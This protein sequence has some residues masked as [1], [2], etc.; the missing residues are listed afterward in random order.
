MLLLLCGLVCCPWHRTASCSS[1][2]R[3]LLIAVC[4]GSWVLPGFFFFLRATLACT[5]AAAAPI[6]SLSMPCRAHQPSHMTT[7][8]PG[9][10]VS[11]Q[12]RRH[13]HAPIAP[14][15][16]VCRTEHLLLQQSPSWQ[17]RCQGQLLRPNRPQAINPYA[18]LSS[19]HAAW[20]DVCLMSACRAVGRGPHCAAQSGDPSR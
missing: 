8:T 3:P 1:L 18:A 20:G 15:T 9:N 5:T 12:H 16:S 17:A 2:L 10:K 7:S 11:V 4:I 13:R 6:Q 14:Q 19:W